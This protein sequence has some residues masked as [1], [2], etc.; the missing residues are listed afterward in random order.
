M[1]AWSVTLD[2]AVSKGV[3][4]LCTQRNVDDGSWGA[5]EADKYVQT[6][7]AVIALG[8][9]NQQ[10]AA[11]YGGVAWLGNHAPANIDFTARR[12]LAL[13]AA[14]R[15]IG[16]DLAVL[17]AAQSLASPGNNGWGLSKT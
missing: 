7:E 14:N 2:A 11:Y 8:A 4:W 17:Q 9:L 6:S 10:N 5:S 1:P 13:G 3:A 12:V 15:T 16:A